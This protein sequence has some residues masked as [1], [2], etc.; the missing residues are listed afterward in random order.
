MTVD[1]YTDAAL[2][3]Y[4]GT[5]LWTSPDYDDDGN[6][7]NDL[8]LNYDRDDMA[9]EAVASMRTDLHDFVTSNWDDVKDMEPGRCGHDFWLTRNR[10]GAGFWDRGLGER[11]D[12]LTAN[13]HPYGESNLYVGDDGRVYVD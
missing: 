12:R 13:A 10:C 3:Q 5:A 1:E 9:P 8:D 6:A 2:P 4:I 11:G 7:T